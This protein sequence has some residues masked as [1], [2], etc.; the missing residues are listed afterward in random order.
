IRSQV[1]LGQ[2]KQ[3]TATTSGTTNTAVNWLVNCR[4]RRNSTVGTIS[5]AGLYT[6][7]SSVPANSVTVTAQSAYDST[8]SA[9]ATVT[10]TPSSQPVY[11]SVSA[12]SASMHVGPSQ[13]FT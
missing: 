8:S 11:V 10:V 13:L 7:P 5:S 3:V 9:N 4:L 6:A 12:A 2:T 1:Q